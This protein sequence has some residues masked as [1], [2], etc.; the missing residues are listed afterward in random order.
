MEKSH[1]AGR[2]SSGERIKSLKI[3]TGTDIIE[4]ERVKAAIKG[5]KGFLDKVFT[6]EEQ[7]YCRSRGKGRYESFAARFAAKEA[8]SKALGCGIGSCFGLTECQILNQETTGAPSITFTGK[9]LE[10]LKSLGI[11]S[12]SVSLSHTEQTAIA[13]VT[14][15]GKD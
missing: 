4:V 2:S 10:Q 3:Y 14:M 1:G 13:T 6:P 11:T 15:I 7:A 12:W 9:A 5:T 8:A